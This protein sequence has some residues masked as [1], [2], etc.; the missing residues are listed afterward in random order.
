M[1]FIFYI[2][3]I[4]INNMISLQEVKKGI[5]IILESGRLKG[6]IADGSEQA[7]CAIEP[8][9]QYHRFGDFLKGLRSLSSEAR[10]RFCRT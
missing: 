9:S 10:I 1:I 6:I 5:R 7:S 4:R 3:L 2:E 8:D